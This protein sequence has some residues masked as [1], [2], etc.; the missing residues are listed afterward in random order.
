MRSLATPVRKPSCA[1]LERTVPAWRWWRSPSSM[2]PAGVSRPCGQSGLPILVRVHQHRHHAE[3]S[4]I[5]ATEVVQPEIEAALTIVRHSLDLLGVDHRL[6]RRYMEGA[7]AHWPEAMRSEGA[8][9]EPLQAMEIA[10]RDPALEG[11]S[12]EQAHIRERSGAA[13]VSSTRTDGRE[14]VNPRSDER[15]RAGDR[16]LVIGTREQLDSLR[17]ICREDVEPYFPG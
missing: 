1:T 14:I 4:E 6:A 2:P 15:L 16:L 17:H 10:V 12:I 13:I 8:S 3:L 9:G 11:Q 7:R 5:G